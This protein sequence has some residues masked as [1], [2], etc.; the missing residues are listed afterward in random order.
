MDRIEQDRMPSDAVVVELRCSASP[1]VVWSVLA[2]GF[3]YASWVV[4]ASHVRAVD[5][6]W[7]DAGSRL[8]HAVGS[9]PLLLQD[10]TSVET[11]IPEESLALLASA[12]P[13]GHARVRIDLS[14]DGSGCLVSMHEAPAST[15]L[16]ASLPRSLW[17][18]LLR[19]RNAETLRRLAA[20][21]ERREEPAA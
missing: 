18:P 8:Y 1:A 16:R 2:D 13:F 14:P 19:A 3:T 15:G 4:G 10:S 5:P 17:A 6:T 12:R 7:P 20:L 9:W 11:A 21:A